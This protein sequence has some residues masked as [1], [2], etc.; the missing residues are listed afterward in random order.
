MGFATESG[1]GPKFLLAS[2]ARPTPV[3]VEPGSVPV[4]QKRITMQLHGA[5]LGEAL[6]EVEAQAGIRMVYSAGV[7]PLDMR[8]SLQAEEISVA[9]ALTELLMGA[10]VDVVVSGNQ[11]ALVARAERPAARARAPGGIAGRVTEEGTGTPVSNAHIVVNGEGRGFT[12]DNGDYRIGN[13]EPGTYVV[14]ITSI[15]YHADLQ[16]VV[17]AD[18]EWVRHDVALAVAPTALNEIVVTA[19]GRQR[20]LEL[21]HDITLLRADSI[22]ANEPISSMADLLEGRVPGL[23]VQ[24]SSGAPGDPAR[25]RIRGASSPLLSNDPIIVIDGVRVYSEQSNARGG[26]LARGSVTGGEY[27]A[28][29]PLDY[30]DP[31]TVET[32]QVIKGPS[33]ATLYGQDAA[34]GVIVI[35][36]KKGRE[37]PARWTVGTEYGTSEL[38]GR[39]PE[40][41]LRWGH[42]AL[43]SAPVHCPVNGQSGG[44]GGLACVADSITTFQILNAPDL[45][46]LDRGHR[47]GVNVGVSGGG[48]NLTYSVTASYADEVGLLRLP[49]YAEE[50]IREARGVAPPEWM[51]RP[52]GLEYW[53]VAS[54]VTAHLGPKADVSL[55]TAL[56]RTEQ[57]RSSLERQL[58][59]LMTTYLNQ[60][61]GKYWRANANGVIDEVTGE[62]LDG[63]FER[64]T[65]DATQFRNGVSLNWRPLSWLT[66]TADAG[67]DVVQRAA[68]VFWPTGYG[69]P[70]SSMGR[71]SVG[72]GTSIVSTVNLRATADASLPLGFKLRVSAG[73]NYY[74]SSIR[75]FTGKA[76]GLR[77]GSESLNG[78]EELLN[79]SQQEFGQSTFGWYVEPSINHR[80]FWLSTGLRLDGGTAHG[81]R[82]N[83]QPFPKVSVSYLVSDESFFPDALRSVFNT[84][85][86]RAAYGDAG[87]QPGPTDRL[88]LYGAKIPV[89]IGDEYVDGVLLETLGN[90]KLKP[91]RS[92]EF[93]FGFDGDLLDDRFAVGFTGYRKTTKDALL[94]VPV[95][96]SVYG[97]DVTT[98][99]NIG[100]VRNTGVELTVGGQPVRSDFLTWSFS[101]T[102]GQ[103][104]NEVVQLGPGVEPFATD[105]LGDSIYARVVPGYPLNGLWTKPIVGYS[106]AN[107][108]GI[109]AED[110]VLLGDTL[111]Y[112]GSQLPDYAVN[113]HTTLS[114]LRGAV[115]VTAA[116]TY[117]D[118]MTQANTVLE[119]LAPFSRAWNDPSTPIDEQAKTLGFASYYQ[120]QTVHT[121]RLNSLSVQYTLPAQVA[122][123]VFRARSVAVSLQGTNLWLHTNYRGLDPNVNGNA[124]TPGIRDTGVLPPPRTWQVRVNASY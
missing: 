21:G 41:M 97:E 84:L 88:R 31:N 1:R 76:S 90:T 78:A 110:E 37:G 70:G 24:R 8:V 108:D 102:Y 11:A 68:S 106:D 57:Q 28:P 52:Q 5:R 27:A 103:N 62:A 7:V 61:T 43:E 95:A 18:G 39:Y 93:E 53:S 59:T 48:R 9:A 12:D 100:V 42:T 51:R 35:T 85:R 23:I 15:G 33:A 20:K 47:T 98:L 86:L 120:I 6:R 122:A 38:P 63:F 109:L 55:S 10:D 2:A 121:L 124:I 64:A 40:L 104:R 99:V 74:G 14:V 75:D 46:V 96:P 112:M 45:T 66:A 4:L 82:L 17:V 49:A 36:T 89:W 44:N 101:L 32:V 50:G 116:L 119:N 3:R 107:R 114:L 29:S 91:E 16:E 65:E 58:G 22:V 92:R 117:E 25:I 71:L 115:S 87:R 81:A 77:E 79:L 123:R 80:R 60:S 26:N 113:L 30:I 19:T 73:A 72:N 105:E 67:M 118:G 56:S 13:V 83:L 34:N 54:R 94:S 111:V 69:S